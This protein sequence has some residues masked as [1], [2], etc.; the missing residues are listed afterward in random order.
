MSDERKWASWQE[1]GR[2]TLGNWDPY[3][4]LTI[5]QFVVKY[6]DDVF[7]KYIQAPTLDEAK[8]ILLDQMIEEEIDLSLVSFPH[9]GVPCNDV[10]NRLTRKIKD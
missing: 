4:E 9:V 6:D 1:L 10:L 7:D 3:R 8:N 2:S 5:Y